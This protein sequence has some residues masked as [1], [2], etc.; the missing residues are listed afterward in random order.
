ML[1]Q[2]SLQHMMRAGPYH[3]I[4]SEFLL[5]RAQIDA[6]QRKEIR[7]PHVRRDAVVR[8]RQPVDMRVWRSGR[9]RIVRAAQRDLRVAIAQAVKPDHRIQL[10]GDPITT[11]PEPR[12][13]IDRF[14]AM[15]E[16]SNMTAADL[17]DEAHRLRA[18]ADISN[19]QVAQRLIAL[20]EAFEACAKSKEIAYS[21]AG[22]RLL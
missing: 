10:R 22:S 6:D 12:S 18:A 14:R 2:M 7:H 4:A 1:A 13:A 5:R 15:T 20:A 3:E 19:E 11:N 9:A 16:R 21:W 17:R 8:G